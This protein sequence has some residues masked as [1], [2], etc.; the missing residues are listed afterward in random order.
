MYVLRCSWSYRRS[1]CWHFCHGSNIT[2][3]KEVIS[4]SLESVCLRRAF[5]REAVTEI[6]G[7]EGDDTLRYAVTTR[8]IPALRWPAMRAGH[9][10]VLLIVR[11]KATRQ[12]LKRE[13]GRN[14]SNRAHELPLFLSVFWYWSSSVT[15][16]KLHQRVQCGVTE[17]GK[18]LETFAARRASLFSTFVVCWLV[19]ETAG[20]FSRFTIASMVS[21]KP[22]MYVCAASHRSEASPS[23]S[24][25]Q[26]QSRYVRLTDDGLFS[27]VLSRKAAELF[28]FLTPLSARRS[29]EKSN[30]SHV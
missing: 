20:R 5:Y 15:Y 25:K 14:V 23:L 30:N 19:L 11:D 4:G 8:T 26:F 29:K 10:N 7:N 28:L 3:H 16:W 27:M 22:I 24:F 12:P 6:P 13:E 21:E 17:I 18:V 1:S 2:A 9:F